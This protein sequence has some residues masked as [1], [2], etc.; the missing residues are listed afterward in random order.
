MSRRSIT[1]RWEFRNPQTDQARQLTERYGLH[2][3]VASILANRGLSLEHDA[4]VSFMKPQL[5][6]LHDPFLMADMGVGVDR[7]V[8]AIERGEKVVV[9]GD[10]D[11]D[12]ITSTS[13][14]MRGLK[15]A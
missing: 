5:A 3:I 15:H 10:Y 12:G 8:A 7:M 14:M 2:S 4:L 11:A 6:T 13:L 1:Y 9:F